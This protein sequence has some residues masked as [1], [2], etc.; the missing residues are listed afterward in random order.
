MILN[1]SCFDGFYYCFNEL[2]HC[3]IHRECVHFRSSTYGYVLLVQEKD[4]VRDGLIISL[5]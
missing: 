5:Y 4:H 1:C 2:W 3:H